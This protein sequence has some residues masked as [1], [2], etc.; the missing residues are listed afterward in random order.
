[1][2]TTDIARVVARAVLEDIVESSAASGGPS[3]TEALEALDLVVD[4]L[5][6]EALFVTRRRKRNV[7][8]VV[9]LTF[10]VP[11]DPTTPDD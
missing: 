4:R 5:L 10:V 11:P 1:M 2:P 3:T 8:E 9:E 7:G 6:T